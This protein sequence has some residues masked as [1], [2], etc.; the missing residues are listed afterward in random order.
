VKSKTYAHQIWDA[1]EVSQPMLEE[2]YDRMFPSRAAFLK[3]HW[4]WLYRVGLHEWARSPLAVISGD[5]V[6]GYAGMIPVT[7]HCK[8]AKLPAVW[9]VDLAILPEHQRQGIGI[10]LIQSSMARCSLHLGFCNERSLGALQKCGWRSRLHTYSFQLLLRPELHPR[11]Q[12][13]P[14]TSV[15]KIAGLATRIVWRARTTLQHE[16][17]VDPI[18]P[19]DLVDFSQ[20]YACSSLHVLRSNE[21]LQWRI[22]DHP[23]A[24]EHLILR[25]YHRRGEGCLTLARLAE[26]NGYRRLHLLVLSGD[27]NKQ[28]ELSE[29]FASIVRWAVERDVHRILMVSSDHNVMSVARWWFPIS[30]RLRF[31]YHTS[32]L[33]I[34]KLLSTEDHMWECID[35]DFDLT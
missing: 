20:Q 23:H 34:D 25:F 12:E 27:L 10:S 4:R 35:N 7:L 28:S 22:A 17:V 30:T 3:Q 18:A 26:V 2:F 16:L 1:T 8:S 6:I 19:D 9:L 15:S 31:I 29:F 33:S 5:R 11:V 24:A 32:D 21:F 13:T 14:F